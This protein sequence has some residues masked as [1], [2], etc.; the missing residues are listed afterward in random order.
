MITGDTQGEVID[1]TKAKYP[2]AEMHVARVRHVGPGPDHIVVGFEP[3]IG[4][5]AGQRGAAFD[6]VAS[7]T[8]FSTG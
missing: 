5:N 6:R 3:G 8:L 1:Q 4:G 2:D 7:A